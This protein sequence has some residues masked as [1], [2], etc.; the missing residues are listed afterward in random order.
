MCLIN[1]AIAERGIIYSL[2]S[3]IFSPWGFTNYVDF[4]STT[5]IMDSN[6]YLPEVELDSPM[7]TFADPVS[8]IQVFR[9]SQS[10]INQKAVVD[11]QTRQILAVEPNIHETTSTWSPHIGQNFTN[12]TDNAFMQAVRNSRTTRKHSFDIFSSGL[13]CTAPPSRHQLSTSILQEIIQG[14]SQL[15][16]CKQVNT[17]FLSTN[18]T[19]H[20]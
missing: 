6:N 20:S 5:P 12:A 7:N 15:R 17:D 9:C 3:G 14:P 13:G 11:A 8:S 18:Y 16:T 19:P 4:Y 10:L 2:E 1:H